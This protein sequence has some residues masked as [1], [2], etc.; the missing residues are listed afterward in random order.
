M[1][2]VSHSSFARPCGELALHEVVVDGRSGFAVQ[3]AFFENVDQ[4]R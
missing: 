2:S 3:A 1:M 4:I